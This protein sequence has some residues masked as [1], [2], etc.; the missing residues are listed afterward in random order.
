MTQEEHLKQIEEA[1]HKFPNGQFD[2]CIYQCPGDCGCMFIVTMDGET[3]TWVD[4]Y[5]PF[6]PHGVP[7][8]DCECHALTHWEEGD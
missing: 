3:A 7:H 8:V 1:L 5:I 6:D 2:G 4:R